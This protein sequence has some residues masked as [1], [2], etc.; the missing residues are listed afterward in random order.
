[1]QQKKGETLQHTFAPQMPPYTH[2]KNPAKIS[3]RII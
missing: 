3:N 1:L 2:H